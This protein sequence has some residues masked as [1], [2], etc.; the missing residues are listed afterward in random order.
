MAKTDPVNTELPTG[1]ATF[2][3]TDIEGSTRLLQELGDQF[4][5]LL[6][7]HH[8]ILRDAVTARDGVVVGTEGDAFFV[9]FPSAARAVEAAVAAQRGLDEAAWPAGKAVRVRMGL[10]TGEATLGGDNYVG[11]DVHRAARI[12]S[13]GHGGQVLVSEAT[14]LLVRDSLPNGVMLRDLGE[15]RLKDLS[16]PERIFQLD[17]VDHPTE[18]PPLKSLDA[19]PNNLPIQLTS[20]VG[21]QHEVAEG[22]RLIRE[23]RLVTLTG[24][25]GTGKTRLSL[26]IAAEAF[27]EFPDGTFFVALAAITDAD[28]VPGAIVQALGLQDTGGQPPAERLRDHVRD[29]QVLLVL[30]NFEQVLGAAPVI[31]DVLRAAPRVKIIVSSRAALRVYGEQEFP[32]PPLGLPDLGHLPDVER[33]SQYEA[34]KLFIERAAAAKPDFQVTNENAPAVA[35]ICSRLD[36]LPLALELAAARIKLLPPQA[37]LGR[38]EHAL[39]LLSGGARDLPERQQT[40]RGAIAWSYDMLDAPVQRL[41]ARFGVFRGGAPFEIAEAICGGDGVDVFDGLST[42][43]DQSLVRQSDDAGEARFWMLETIREFAADA[44][45]ESGEEAAIKQRHADAYLALAEATAPKLMGG[46]QKAALDRMEADH[47]NLRAAL[48]WLVERHDEE[49]A[50]RLLFACWRF[51]QMRGYIYE[52]RER[53]DAVIRILAQDSHFARVLAFEAAGGLA[54][55]GGDF[56]ATGQHYQKALDAARALGDQARL[57]TALYN[58]AFSYTHW[59]VDDPEA[60]RAATSFQEEALAIYESLGDEDGVARCH[61]GLGGLAYWGRETD[62][63]AEHFA[64]C[65]ASFRRAGNRFGLAWARHMA[66]LNLMEM[67]DA[68]G[69]REAFVEAVQ[70]F[71]EARD[72]SGVVLCLDDFAQLNWDGQSTERA[73]WLACAAETLEQRSGVKLASV[74]NRLG[75]P[76]RPSDYVNDAEKQAWLMQVRDVTLEQAVEFALSDRPPA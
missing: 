27:D 6:D 71:L 13:C 1:T 43:L 54:Y 14:Q 75:R 31:A 39:P 26:Q 72:V 42:L 25:G 44:L 23:H 56:P 70:L 67:K 4:Q 65:E 29:K 2:L 66:G 76:G 12:A 3:F 53:A 9:V 57:A 51:W 21:R 28:L 73:L 69:A 16:R 22:L 19:M 34:V 60:R 61:W 8:R 11:I 20:F 18:F 24:P 33:L 15:H 63:A 37:M 40:L 68:T 59:S 62:A 38:L 48:T 46:E 74:S 58:M 45:R 10:H 36:G 50:A 64:A 7:Q 41:L 17:I 55:W 5:T 49:A 30:D 52:G 47:D 35:A 32:V